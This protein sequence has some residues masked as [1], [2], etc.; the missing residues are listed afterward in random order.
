MSKK[1]TCEQR[2]ESQGMKPGK[3][4]RNHRLRSDIGEC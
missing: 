1:V 4:Q 2:R 3:V